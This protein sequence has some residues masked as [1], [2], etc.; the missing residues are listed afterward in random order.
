VNNKKAS[1]Q[2]NKTNQNKIMHLI[3]ENIIITAK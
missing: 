1:K 2:A 3:E